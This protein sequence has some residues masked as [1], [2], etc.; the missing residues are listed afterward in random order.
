M[1]MQM[2]TY[3]CE[4]WLRI[5][6]SLPALL[7]ISILI[8][9]PAFAN[10]SDGPYG[11]N[12]DSEYLIC[13]NDSNSSAPLQSEQPELAP[14]SPA[15][16]GGGENRSAPRAPA[17]GGGQENSAEYGASQPNYQGGGQPY[18][19]NRG[20]AQVG[21]PANPPYSPQYE[22]GYQG[23]EQFN[24]Q[25]QYPRLAP[26][27]APEFNNQ[28]YGQ[29]QYNSPPYSSAPYGQQPY[30]TPN[31]YSGRPPVV[32]PQ[33]LMIPVSLQT[34]ISTQVAKPGDYIQGTISQNVSLSGRGYIPAGTQIVGSVASST[35]G[36][37]L[38][39]SGALSIQ[40]NSM[41]FPDGRLVQM[42][43][44]LVGDIGKYKNKGQGQND[45]YRGEGWEA[46]VG[47]SLLR[48]GLGAGLGAGL[49]TAVGGIAGGGRGAGR[50]AWSGAAIGGGI[51]LADMFLRKGRDVIVPAGTEIQIQ[52]DEP[53]NIDF[54]GGGNAYGGTY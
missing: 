37:R 42:N 30:Q 48:G 44:H 12:F 3:C 54:P 6:R 35:A 32:A 20:G 29:P 26:T 50:G 25:Q 22:P 1:K 11:L 51:G 17:Y 28:G 34:A 23:Q 39:R 31:L 27:E 5:Q 46:K 33:G 38:S 45:L 7:S 4:N 47:Q 53:V 24:S 52:L 16:G 21:Y 14:E 10:G 40:F 41:R 13:Q 19:G 9:S 18:P 36:R 2:Q 8:A 49:G 15:Q 43:A